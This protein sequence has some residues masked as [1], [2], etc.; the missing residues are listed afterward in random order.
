MCLLLILFSILKPSRCL[1]TDHLCLDRRLELAKQRRHCLNIDGEQEAEDR[2]RS[3]DLPLPWKDPTP[4]AASTCL[5]ELISC[6]NDR[7]NGWSTEALFDD[8]LTR[9]KFPLPVGIFRISLLISLSNCEAIFS[10][11]VDG[12]PCSTAGGDCYYSRSHLRLLLLQ[13]RI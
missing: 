7:L 4:I 12:C 1:S 2:Y 9:P 5:D 10:V 13:P 3:Y 8:A 6:N 11:G